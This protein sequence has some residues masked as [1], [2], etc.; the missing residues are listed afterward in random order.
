MKVN[1]AVGERIRE[2]REARGIK[3]EVLAR[4]AGVGRTTLRAYEN[5][6]NFSIREFER[7]R[8]ALGVTYMEFFDSELFSERMAKQ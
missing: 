6:G 8:K 4:A 5:G 1:E 3:R 7:V 2:I